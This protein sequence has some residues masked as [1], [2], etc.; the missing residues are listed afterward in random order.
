MIK[1][2]TGIEKAISGL[3]YKLKNS[4]QPPGKDEFFKK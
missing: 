3:K 4:P 1:I 2:D